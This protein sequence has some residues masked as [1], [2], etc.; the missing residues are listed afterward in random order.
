MAPSSPQ[1][2]DAAP[3]TV[4]P[5][6]PSGV[7]FGVGLILLSGQ[8]LASLLG[9]AVFHAWRRLAPKHCDHRAQLFGS[10]LLAGDG[11]A[12]VV[13]SCLE[14]AG[15]APPFAFAYPPWWPA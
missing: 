10:A 6:L 9:L 4:E 11:L 3:P 2:R 13:Q 12:G 7:A 8:V 15:V 5:Y 1:A 14:A